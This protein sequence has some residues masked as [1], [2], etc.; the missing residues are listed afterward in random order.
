M[1]NLFLNNINTNTHNKVFQRLSDIYFQQTQSR[2]SRPDSKLRTYNIIK[3]NNGMEPYLTKIK[4]LNYRKSLT[5]FRLSNHDL[6]IEA[7]RH[8]KTK[9]PKQERF[10]PFCINSVEDEIHFLIN[11]PTYNNLRRE[12]VNDCVKLRPNFSYYTDT[13]KFIF[14]LTNETISFKLPKLVHLAMEKRNA[15]IST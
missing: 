6:T 1:T 12:I 7:G 9:I 13:D 10:C 5:K 3:K 14:L 4:N 11:C 2:I 15:L 8:K